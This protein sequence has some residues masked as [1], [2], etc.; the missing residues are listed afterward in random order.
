MWS[1]TIE[2]VS[3]GWVLR[4]PPD[5]PE[6]ATERVTVIQE[7]E[8]AAGEETAAISVLWEVAEYFGLLGRWGRKLTIGYKGEEEDE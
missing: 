6:T 7:S 2:K 4:N 3:N 5:D 1:L 8:L